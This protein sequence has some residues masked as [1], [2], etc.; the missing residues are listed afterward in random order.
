[1]IIPSAVFAVDSFFLMSGFLGSLSMMRRI[2]RGKNLLMEYPVMVLHRFLR[3]SPV[4]FV[5][6]FTMT[7]GCWS[8]AAASVFV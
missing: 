6:L 2:D 7:C 3:L 4:Y 8:A 5:A 1:M